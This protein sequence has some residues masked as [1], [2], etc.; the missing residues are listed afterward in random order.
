MGFSTKFLPFLDENEPKVPWVFSIGF[1]VT[2][3]VALNLF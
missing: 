2:T 3:A 1:S